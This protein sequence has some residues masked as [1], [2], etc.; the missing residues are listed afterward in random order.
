MA[1]KKLDVIALTLSVL[2]FQFFLNVFS[3]KPINWNLIEIDSIIGIISYWIAF[4]L[5]KN[6]YAF[7]KIPIMFYL[8]ILGSTLWVLGHCIYIAYFDWQ[9]LSD[10]RPENFYERNLDYLMGSLIYLAPIVSINAL[11]FIFLFRGLEKISFLLI[12]MV[13]IRQ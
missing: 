3:M 1:I 2:F 9:Y 11:L 5:L 10:I 4:L 12:K 7:L 8:V 6:K 13:G